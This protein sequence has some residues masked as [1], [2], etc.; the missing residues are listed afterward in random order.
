MVRIPA[1]AK[2]DHADQNRVG[3]LL[4]DA[5]MMIYCQWNLEH[6]FGAKKLLNAEHMLRLLT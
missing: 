4:N 6:S 3:A 1:G 2:C 5:F